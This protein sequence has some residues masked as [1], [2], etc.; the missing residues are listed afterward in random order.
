[1]EKLDYEHDYEECNQEHPRL[2]RGIFGEMTGAR[3]GV[4]SHL[5][6]SNRLKV[7]RKRN[8]TVRCGHTN[9]DLAATQHQAGKNETF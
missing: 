3:F 7:A 6:L 1:M 5:R 9:P 2:N 8:R 4:Q